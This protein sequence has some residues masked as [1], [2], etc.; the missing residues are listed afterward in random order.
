MIIFQTYL[1]CIAE[2][3][4]PCFWINQL[5]NLNPRHLDHTISPGFSFDDFSYVAAVALER[6][7]VKKP[8]E[9]NNIK[10]DAEMSRILGFATDWFSSNV[11]VILQCSVIFSSFSS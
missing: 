8:R 9:A 11:R 10:S 2:L 5:Q 3:R 6:V 1:H 4:A 7:W